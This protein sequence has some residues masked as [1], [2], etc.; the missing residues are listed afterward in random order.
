MR[1]FLNLIILF[2]TSIGLGF[3][4]RAFFLGGQEEHQKLVR[5]LPTSFFQRFL[6]FWTLGLIV[7]ILLTIIN[8]SLNKWILKTHPTNLKKVFILGLLA[9]TSSCLVF[10]FF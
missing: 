7:L 1:Q 2:I 9:I 5:E 8:W 6:F 3:L 10:F 4:S